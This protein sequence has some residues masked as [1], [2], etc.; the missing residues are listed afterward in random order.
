MAYCGS[1]VGTWGSP[2]VFQIQTLATAPADLSTCQ[3]VLIPGSEYR[4]T[5]QLAEL[6]GQQQAQQQ[7]TTTGTPAPS[8]VTE[9]QIKEPEFNVERTQDMMEMFW[10]FVLVLVS[11]W[12]LKQL[13]NL[14]STDSDK[15]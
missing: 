14:F 12:G 6:Q 2:A 4:T 13:L 1:S 7:G 5:L 11:I 3:F 10:A 9:L 15:D 8:T